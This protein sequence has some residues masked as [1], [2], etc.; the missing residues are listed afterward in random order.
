MGVMSTL[1]CAR[2][3][4]YRR[5]SAWDSDRCLLK[6]GNKNSRP[7]EIKESKAKE[8][9][10]SILLDRPQGNAE[11]LGREPLNQG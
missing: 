10:L 4:Q 3:L 2:N 6:M 8:D 1:G 11:V 9:H 7:R 5:L